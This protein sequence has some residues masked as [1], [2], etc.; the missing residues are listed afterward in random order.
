MAR[1]PYLD[2]T[3]LDPADRDLLKRPINLFR[4]LVHSPG[5]ARA[6]SGLGSFIRYRSTLDPR[7]REMAILQVGYLTRSE[8]EYTHHVRLGTEQFGVSEAD[9]RA[10]TLESEG[11]DSGLPETDRAVLAAAR[12]MV[13][14]LA[15][16]DDTF[17]VLENSLSPEHL[18]DLVVT[19]AF[20]CG[21]VRI[22]ATLQIDN[23]PHYKAVL[24]RFP[25]PD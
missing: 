1:L 13:S 22:L 21:V 12:A 16:P 18:V 6:L 10:I 4:Q 14:D 24:D 25:L 5:A 19:I 9:I 20:Y 3:D 11:G 23:E 15:V 7:L 2:T 8:Y 17:A